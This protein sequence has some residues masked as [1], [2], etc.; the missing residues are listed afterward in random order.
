MMASFACAMLLSCTACRSGCHLVE[1][2]EGK[3]CLSHVD[4]LPLSGMVPW[5][6]WQRSWLPA[7]GLWMPADETTK[8]TKG[9]AF[10]E[11]LQPEVGLSLA[12]P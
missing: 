11:Y 7:G 3:L 5:D 2:H 1:A 8:L 6:Q 12:A 10:V 4:R 9:F